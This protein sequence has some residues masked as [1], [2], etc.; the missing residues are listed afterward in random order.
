M[1]FFRLDPS[2]RGKGLCELMTKPI[3]AFDLRRDFVDDKDYDFYE[4]DRNSLEPNCPSTL[5]GPGYLHS[6][7]LNSKGDWRQGPGYQ[8][9]FR[10]R[11]DNWGYQDKNFLRDPYYRRYQ[12]D[13]RR[14][15]TKRYYGNRR[16]YED[17]FF[18][19]YQIGV[20][21]SNEEQETWGQY[22]GVYGGYDNYYKNSNDYRNSLSHWK[23]N[24]KKFERP[25]HFYGVRPYGSTYNDFNYQN[26]GN[27]KTGSWDSNYGYGYGAS[28]RSW[29]DSR[30]SSDWNGLSYGESKYYVSKKVTG[31]SFY[32]DHNEPPVKGNFSCIFVI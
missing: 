22:G 9:Q 31:N 27:R 26:L 11:Y 25:D 1:I 2:F 4:L 32:Q 17:Q 19:P 23:V 21:R 16:R 6:G 12:Y 18:I 14:G 28:R 24:E 30:Q 10:D 29:N 13:D 7:Y 20:G 15:D 5:R 8:E 3:E